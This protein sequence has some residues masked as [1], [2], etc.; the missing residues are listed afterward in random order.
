MTFASPGES[1]DGLISQYFLRISSQFRR[2]LIAHGSAI[3]GFVSPRT[4]RREVRNLIGVSVG[5]QG[6]MIR[7]PQTGGRITPV[8]CFGARYALQHGY[9]LE[10]VHKKCVPDL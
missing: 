9:L 1:W 4:S 2:Q 6:S 7:R 3:D 8:R 10:S 5:F